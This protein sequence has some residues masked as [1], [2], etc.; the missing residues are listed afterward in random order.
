MEQNWLLVGAFAFGLFL[1][2]I[3]FKPQ[4]VP[5]VVDLPKPA[6]K[7]RKKR[8]KAK[9][10]PEAI[11]EAPMLA[12]ELSVS[13]AELKLVS[14]QEEELRTLEAIFMDDLQIVHPPLGEQQGHFKLFLKPL[15]DTV[16]N[17]YCTVYLEVEYTKLYPASPPKITL[18]NPV[19]LTNEA[20]KELGEASRQ[21]SEDRA[22][23]SYP[24]ILDICQLIQEKLA[25]FNNEPEPI[26]TPES[27][28]LKAEESKIRKWSQGEQST[29]PVELSV[30]APLNENLDMKKITEELDDYDQNLSRC[31]SVSKFKHEY[32]D[33]ECIGKG[34]GGSVYKA[35]HKLD[36]LCYAIKKVKL[37]SKKPARNVS[38]LREVTLLSRLQ[39]E[40]IVRYYHAWKE[41]NTDSESEEES[42]D[43]WGE[44][45]ESLSSEEDSDESGHD[46]GS[47]D[48]DSSNM[49][50][51]YGISS[52]KK[53]DEYL[54]I[55]MEYCEGLNLGQV[56]EQSLPPV[57]ERWRYLREI[58]EGLVYIHSKGLIHRDLKPNNIFLSREGTVKLGDFGL[59]TTM[60]QPKPDKTKDDS[61][62]DLA[63]L[64]RG[65]GT[66]FYRAPEQD[67]GDK[68]D[69]RADTFSLGVILF[70]LWR[71]FGS[72]MQRAAELTELTTRHRL[73]E[74]F[75]KETPPMV[76]ELVLRL[77]SE[78]PGE[79]P[80]P[81]ELLKN[82]NLPN[83]SETGQ[84]N[85]FLESVLNHKSKESSRLIAKLFER[86]NPSGVIYH[87]TE[88]Q[89]TDSNIR[90]F[91]RQKK[92]DAMLKCSIVKKVRDLFELSGGV[93]ISTPLVH[94]HTPNTTILTYQKG[95][96]SPFQ[97]KSTE[98]IAT[99][100]EPSGLIVTLPGNLEMPWA[101]HL[102]EQNYGG[103]LKRY[104]IGNVYRE[105][106]PGVQPKEQLEACF[107]ICFNEG[108]VVGEKH[109]LE[110]ELIKISYD[111]IQLLSNNFIEP[112]VLT[113]SISDSRL[114]DGILD[115][116]CVPLEK[117]LDVLK[118]L[119]HLERRKWANCK[120][121]LVSL[122]LQ[123][124]TCEKLASFFKLK[125]SLSFVI[126]QLKKTPIRNDDKFN[127]VLESDFK[128]LF[129]FFDLFGIERVEIDLGLVPE[130]LLYYSGLLF[131]ISAEHIVEGTRRVKARTLFAVGG[132]YDNL[133]R[134]FEAQ[135]KSQHMSAIGVR[136]FLERF[137]LL[138]GNSIEIDRIITG[139]L[140]F[141]ASHSHTSADMSFLLRERIKL[142]CS[143]WKN[144]ISCLYMYNQ[145]EI[146][147]IQDLCKRYHIRF[148]VIVRAEHTPTGGPVAAFRVKDFAYR[149]QMREE[150]NVLEL[151]TNRLANVKAKVVLKYFQQ[152]AKH[153]I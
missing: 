115:H 19:N 78:V 32:Q 31:F 107:D 7:I 143:L 88:S 50:S 94:L 47:F 118:I 11:E 49:S 101:R 60:T 111:C 67:K 29:I 35:R 54:Y 18:K 86:P 123:P 1:G 130:N 6:K 100:I 119:Y 151:V 39:H 80:T 114:I 43:D 149:E 40:H 64:S 24:S 87:L 8:K 90:Q 95:K 140:V 63:N 127:S 93:D 138:S 112:P 146:S 147:E 98:N 105:N 53:S 12:E 61:K 137:I 58:L 122:G 68:Y 73:P 108:F 126:E 15:P 134:H 52:E 59:A 34:A 44:E 16:T 17:V 152:K 83:I 62:N 9:A 45:S 38:L 116:C 55:K 37:N 76:V 131:R 141:I 25:G 125:G 20:L 103:V 136:I 21:K 71:E 129:E 51:Y 150:A 5:V 139:P 48:E 72:R 22:A 92:L 57:E 89:L 81:T 110:A 41:E 128:S 109:V 99:F 27:S 3:L 102:A 145:I 133:I 23:Y 85:E 30:I 13:S 117:R 124:A 144:S 2:Y 153:L 4:I 36:G 120:E 10:I 121:D 104:S 26:L 74:D 97:Y 84:F 91:R 96:M 106:S 77:T 75:I 79:R 113:I 66:I 69:Q 70:E 14:V 65:V 46:W 132:R 135:D 148:L 33:V 82:E 56:L 28:S 42:E 142:T